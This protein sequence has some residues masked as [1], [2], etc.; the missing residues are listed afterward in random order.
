LPIAR[1]LACAALLAAACSRST[2]HA[3]PSPAV[4]VPVPSPVP[5]GAPELLWANGG[6]FV[7]WCQTGWYASPALADLDGDGVPEVIWGAYDVTALRASD[8]ALLWRAPDGGRVWAP[9]AVADLDGDGAPEVVVGR[10]GDLLTVYGP[11]GRVRWSRHPFGGGEVRSVAVADL[12]GDGRLEIVVGRGSGGDYEQVAAYSAGG[13]LL[14]GF[15]ARHAGEPGDGWGMYNQNLAIADLD[16]DG[17]KEIVAPTD[18]H[19]IT[20]LDRLGNQLPVSSRYAPHTVWSDVGVHVD[21]KA[22][23]RGYAICGTEHRPNF[24]HSA[25]AVG[26]LDGDGTREI[27]AVG[28]VYDCG[29]TPYRSLYHMPFVL[30][31]DR[32]RWKAGPFDWT[33]IPPPRADGAPLSESD[34]VIFPALPNA[35]LADLDGDGKKEILFASWDGKLHAYGPDRQEHGD[36]PFT[37]PGPGRIR[38]ATEPAVADLDG[39]GKAEVIFASWPDLASKARGRLFILDAL[40][41]LA[42]SVELPPSFPAGEWNGGLGAPT[43]ARLA[44]GGDVH[45]FLG[46]S[47]SGVVAFRIPSTGSARLLWPTGRGNLRRDG[48]GP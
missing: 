38:F 42:S 16:G 17:K 11:D 10:D 4:P 48:T 3:P 41:R 29:A 35:V 19:A 46:T 1:S 32:T 39:D 28:N 8:G 12:D 6:C 23:L 43:L 33:V 44:P 47:R 9:I 14:P 31:R 2:A 27:V 30:N 40:G 37:V 24:A 21:E 22:D 18:S 20:A 45:V 15:P 7:S 26:D 34:S 36:W 13:D 25:P 5:Y